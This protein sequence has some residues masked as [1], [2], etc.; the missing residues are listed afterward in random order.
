MEVRW[1]VSI[2]RTLVGLCLLLGALVVAQLR[3]AEVTK[4]VPNLS[5]ADTNPS[6]VRAT[7]AA[8]AQARTD[9]LVLRSR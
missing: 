2:L 4:L 1:I 8:S 9:Y 7:N 3:F 6:W 5:M